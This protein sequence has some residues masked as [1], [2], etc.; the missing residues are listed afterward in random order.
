MKVTDEISSISYSN[1]VQVT[2][3]YEEST[4]NK[5]VSKQFS[6]S[7]KNFANKLSEGLWDLTVNLFVSENEKNFLSDSKGLGPDTSIIIMD[8]QKNML[9]LH[10]MPHKV[11]ILIT[12]QR[13]FIQ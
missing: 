13:Q 10:R 12:Q 1:W 4:C 3:T 8:L 2:N 11:F 9:L 5:T 6:E 7:F